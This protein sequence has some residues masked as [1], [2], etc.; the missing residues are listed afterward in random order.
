MSN[1]AFEFLHMFSVGAAS[2]KEFRL[3]KMFSHGLWLIRY[4]FSHGYQSTYLALG[5][6]CRDIVHGR[7]HHPCAVTL[8]EW[9][10]PNC[11]NYEWLWPIAV[12]AWLLQRMVP[13]D[14]AAEYLWEYKFKFEFVCYDVRC[15]KYEYFHVK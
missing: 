1:Y 10:W 4:N 14:S 15:L 7:C 6:Q 8:D 5:A 13:C 2:W 12:A 3:K 11:E 9:L